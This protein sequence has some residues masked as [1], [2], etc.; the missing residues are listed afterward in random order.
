MDESERFYNPLDSDTLR[1]PD[2]WFSARLV[3][4]LQDS[5]DTDISFLN[6]CCKR[7]YHS[8]RSVSIRLVVKRRQLCLTSGRMR[9][10]T[11]PWHPSW[12]PSVLRFSMTPSFCEDGSLD[13]DPVVI[14]RTIQRKYMRHFAVDP[15]SL[16][17]RFLLDL[18]DLGSAAT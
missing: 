11:P 2:W 8:L 10:C 5:L 4:E 14:H 16:L 6:R 1:G 13:A 15:D 17:Q 18:P 12:A 3:D 9:A 7:V